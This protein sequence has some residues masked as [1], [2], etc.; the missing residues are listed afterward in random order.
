MILTR[1]FSITLTSLMQTGD[2]ARHLTRHLEPGQFL[3]LC[4][5]LGAGKTTLTRLL[6][7][8]LS[9]HKLANSPTFSLLQEYPGGR[10]PVCH[11]DLY[12]L[13]SEDELYDLGWEETIHRFEEGLMVV[14][15]ADKFA[16]ALPEDR[17]ELKLWHGLED[18]E[19][20]IELTAR[21]PRSCRLLENLE[22][23]W[24]KS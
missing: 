8:E 23:S 10:L 22:E 6:T 16:D 21:G 5:D 2:L 24:T 12:R 14:E 15:W 19:R 18:E 11:A 7:Q 17:L 3:A 20:R 13:G 1:K 4:G 9:S